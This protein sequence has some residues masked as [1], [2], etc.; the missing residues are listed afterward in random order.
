MIIDCES[1]TMREI[2]CSDCVVTA[3]FS[4]AP[5]LSEETVEAISLL[6]SRGMVAPL[7]FNSQALG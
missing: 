5:E 2:A 3:L 1:C 6:A 7:Q 4:P